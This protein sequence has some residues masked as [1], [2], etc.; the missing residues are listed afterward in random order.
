[1]LNKLKELSLDLSGD[2]YTDQKTRILYAT[3]A[4]AYRELPI[5]VARPKDKSDLRKL[6]D[7]ANKHNTSLIPRTAGTSLAGQVVGNGIVVD[8]SKYFT[9]IL[10]LNKEERW[11]RVQPGVI[12]DELN[13]FLKPH[14]LFFGPET[15]TSSRCMIGGMVGNNACGSH[16]II[17]GT[18]RDHTLATKVILSDGVEVEFKCLGKEEFEE[19]LSGD[20]VEN[21]IYQ[22]INT[23]LSDKKNQDEIRKEYPDKSIYRRNTGYAIDL[24]LETEPFIS[25]ED[26]FNFSK[27]ICGS[28]GTLGLI[29]E[30]TLN[31]VDTPPENIAVVAAHFKTKEEAFKANLIALKHNPG[32]VEM[33]DNTI[34]N[35]TKGNRDQLKN[36]YFVDGDPGAIL[37]IEFARQT[38]EEIN[39]SCNN[40]IEDLKKSEFGYH[41][42]VIYGDDTKK[43]WALR[44]AGLGVLSNME[45]D[46]RPV[47][48]IEDTSVDVE[49]LPDYMSDFKK[50]MDKHKLECVYHA[51]IGSGE[52][53]LRPILNLK[54]S[55]DVAMF[56]T[57]GLEIAHLV[58]KYNGSLS[59]EHG[60]G[61]V[62]GEFIP[63]I[64]GEHNYKLLHELKSVWDTNNI[65][66]PGKI[67]DVLP[68]TSN[69]RYS[70]DQIEKE[71]KTIFDFSDVGGI[72]RA[73]E[74][75]NGS[76]DC[77]R[78]EKSGGTMCPSYMATRNE[79]DVTRARANI[80]RE[81]LTNSTNKNP[82]DHTEIKEVMDLCLSC[83]AC[84]SECP[85]SVDV[86]KL[87][88]EFLQH[89]YDAHGIPLRSKLIAYITE[90]N[91]FASLLPWFYNLIMKN[92]LISSC[93]MRLI[94]FTPERNMPLL[95]KQTMS[96]WM[97]QYINELTNNKDTKRKVYL[98]N[99]EFT[100]YNDTD[101]GIKTV[102]LLTRLG[103]EVVIPKHIDSGR[104]YL[105]KG[106]L[107]KAKKIAIQNVNYLKDIISTKSPLVGIEPSAILTFRDEYPDLMSDELKEIAL[108]LSKNTLMIDEFLKRE[109]E[110]GNIK[111]EQFTNAKEN[112]KLHGHCQQKAVASTDPT[113]FLLSFPENYSVEE[114]P[115]GCCGMAGSFGYEKEHYKVSMKIGEMVL[116]PA[117]R[118]ASEQ[119]LIAA[120]GTSCRHQIK[121]GTGK[122]ALHPVEIL[123]T[124]LL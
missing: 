102:Q 123:Y 90:I 71:I 97:K 95:S 69:L 118:E 124:A 44:K 113:K 13:M 11:V 10:E 57:I 12:L 104:T 108:E 61:R 38:I 107:R 114:I 99:D 15:S 110:N 14:G 94:G 122:Q 30:I 54:D 42:P 91:K 49:V 56:R 75:C 53:H 116:F 25:T 86:A 36:R 87:K 89:Y 106:L 67:V 20:Q 41:F 40:L 7:F 105:S 35:L 8:I 100:N 31:L 32:A 16:S 39:E 18:T 47:S 92:K 37:I 120:P 6:V 1:M 5:A 27:L 117:V 74:K 55:K 112:I 93:I 51:H 59:G 68:M 4:S 33:M 19:K 78:T 83:K 60:D 115:S 88:A 52:L 121:D 79:N 109:I 65:F 45:G 77:R 28:E 22:H 66:N 80:L 76:G 73:T 29:T 63:I 72:L 48:V 82:F 24:L 84:K 98:F 111:K 96:K 64:I 50:I 101:I 62:R 26:K 58:K 2:L 3:D 21:K 17:Y 119:T 85:S 46:A 9:E 23:V 81:F 34:L 70:P 103:Y 43:V